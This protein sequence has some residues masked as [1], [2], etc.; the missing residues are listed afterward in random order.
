MTVEASTI[1]FGGTMRHLVVP[2]TTL[3]RRLQARDLDALPHEWD[4]QYEL[5]GGV[6]YMS[7]RPSND[8]Q[9]AIA[10]II[11]SVGPAVAKVGG[12]LVPEPGLVWDDAGDDNVSPDVALVL[13]SDLARGAK[14]RATPDIVIEVLSPGPEAHDR[15]FKAKRDLYWRE[16]ARE[17]WIVDTERRRLHQFTR[18]AHGWQ[19]RVLT[20]RGRVKTTLLPKW[21]GTVVSNLLP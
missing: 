13:R 15:D 6:L 3:P 9:I 21:P 14:L 8:H 16:G 12:T 18:G 4:T 10:K 20:S 17:Y 11:L 1:P 19:E 2:L 5:V 7:R